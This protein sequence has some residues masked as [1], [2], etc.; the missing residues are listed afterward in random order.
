MKI[1]KRDI[2]NFNR[3]VHPSAN[4]EANIARGVYQRDVYLKLRNLQSHC[5]GVMG[6]KLTM[7]DVKEWIDY[8]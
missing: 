7:K 8:V 5:H 1:T 4:E 3:G 2:D 6:N